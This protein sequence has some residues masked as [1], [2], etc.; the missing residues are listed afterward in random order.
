[1]TSTLVLIDT[2]KSVGS[3]GISAKMLKCTATSIT[4]TLTTLCNLSISTGVFPSAWKEGRI[5]PVP[6]GTN[7]TSPSGYRPISILPVVSKVIECHIKAII[8]EHLQ[9]NAPI[10]P[11]QWGF[12][13][14]KLTISALIKVVDDWSRALDQGFEVC[15]V[16]F[17]ISKAVDTVPHLP[18]LQQ[19]EKLGLNPYFLRWI[20]SYVSGR[21]QHVLVDGYSSQTLPIISS[22]PQGSVLGPLLF[23][24]YINDVSSVTL[25]GSDMNLFADDIA[26]YR[27]IKSPADYNILQDDIN[28]VSKVISDKYLRFN[29][30]KCK[31]MLITRKRSMSCQPL[32][33]R[34]DGTILTQVSSW[35]YHYIRL[36]LVPSHSSHQQ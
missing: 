15:I 33:L 8:V 20:R 11:R 24:C 9:A 2:T 18:L 32:P 23:I 25:D 10:S 1:M 4:S 12:I 28:T 7:K 6:K 27:V 5:V 16:F 29:K 35:N 34:L 3:D 14:S 21:T 13:S 30:T 19:M 22:V 26:L 36:I 17:D 31:T